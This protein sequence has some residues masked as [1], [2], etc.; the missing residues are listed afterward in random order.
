MF[1]IIDKGTQIAHVLFAKCVSEEFGYFSSD[2]TRGITE[3]MLESIILSMQ[4][5]KKMFCRLGKMQDGFQVDNLSSDSGNV[6]KVPSQKFKVSKV[7]DSMLH[8][9]VIR[10]YG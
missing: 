1:G 8:E 10:V 5:S 7:V 9:S 3:H 4:V 2:I 6:G